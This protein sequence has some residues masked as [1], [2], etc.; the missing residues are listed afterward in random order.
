MP[1]MPPPAADERQ[2]L[3]NFLAF[4]QNAFFAVSY[5]LSDEQARAT[6][7]VSALSI[8]GLIKHATGVQRGWVNRVTSAPDFPPPDPRPME[9]VMA[10]YADQY[11]MRDDETLDQ[12]LAALKAQNADTLRAFAE[13]DL[14][15]PVP[16]PHDVP[17]FPKDIDNWSVRWGAMHLVEELARHAGH[18][19]IIR[20]SIDG[21]T[22]YELMAGIEGWPETD[23]I[24][25]WRA[26]A[27]A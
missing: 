25:P 20:E 14:A 19:D 11:L 15:A 7:S 23:W 12:L 13:A 18:A 9:E 27:T 4:Q 3:L 8:G 17:W 6:P 1:G 16:V 24:K 5:G 21:A 10:E 2:T 22:M 26:Q